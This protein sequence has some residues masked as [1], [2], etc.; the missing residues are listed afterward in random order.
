MPRQGYGGTTSRKGGGDDNM[1]QQSKSTDLAALDSK[2]SN[3]PDRQGVNESRHDF[4]NG[5]R[6]ETGANPRNADERPRES[7]ERP[8]TT[9]TAS[10]FAETLRQDRVDREHDLKTLAEQSNRDVDPFKPF[11]PRG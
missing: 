11:D 3:H 9:G 6:V 7:Y 8:L 4:H 1:G 5:E 2:Y 10:D